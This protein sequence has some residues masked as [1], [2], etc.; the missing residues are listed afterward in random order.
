MP[1]LAAL[2]AA[3][4]YYLLKT[5]GEGGTYVPPPPAVRG[6]TKRIKGF[7]LTNVRNSSNVMAARYL[8]KTT[9]YYT[10]FYIVCE[11]FS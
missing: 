7:P 10:Q 1:N 6:L 4:F 5:D 3:I 9:P 2:R 8:R 11:K